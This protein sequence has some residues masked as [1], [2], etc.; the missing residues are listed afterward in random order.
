[1]T[2]LDSQ[3]LFK[4]FD[5]SYSSSG[6][7]NF[8]PFRT[9]SETSFELKLIS[10]VH[11]NK[12]WKFLPSFFENFNHCRTQ[13]A[14]GFLKGSISILNICTNFKKKSQTIYFR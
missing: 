12:G 5:V 8:R 2:V 10:F 7:V 14:A 3:D 13:I 1:M 4:T 6:L 11:S 9:V